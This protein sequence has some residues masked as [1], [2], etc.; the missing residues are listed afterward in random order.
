[1]FLRYGKKGGPTKFCSKACYLKGLSERRSGKG[2]PHW[3]GGRYTAK[4]YVYILVP[5]HPN[6]SQFG[7]VREHRLVME[8]ALGRFLLPT[9]QVHHLNGDKSDNRPENLELWSKNQPT[10]S[11]LRDVPHCPTCTCG[12]Q[13]MPVEMSMWPTLIRVS[14]ATR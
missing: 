11:R 14:Q 10:G 3:K 7:Y 13:T 8:S 12:H 2:N 4:G 6:A 5:D 1:M 9:E